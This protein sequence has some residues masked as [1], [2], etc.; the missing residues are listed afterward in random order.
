MAVWD[1]LVQ[2]VEQK[3][4]TLI[5]NDVPRTEV[6]VGNR[7]GGL[8]ALV[9]MWEPKEAL[10]TAERY[11]QVM[12]QVTEGLFRQRGH[13]PV[14]LG[15]IC[16]QKPDIYRDWCSNGH[17]WLLDA[18]ARRLLIYENQISSFLGMERE[19]EGF[20]EAKPARL[21]NQEQI[22][23][24][25]IALV[26]VNILIFFVVDVFAP[27][28]RTAY[29]TGKFAMYW[30]S[31]VEGGEYYRLV[32]SMFLHFG[33]AHLVNN[34]LILFVIGSRL[35][36]LVGK[37]KYTLVYLLSGILAGLVSMGYNMLQHREVISAGASGAVFGLVGALIWV[38]IANRG[39]ARGL[40]T[41]QILF[42]AA[43]SL[44]GGFVNRQTDN[45]AHI[46][47]LVAGFLLVM[48]LYHRGRGRKAKGRD[49]TSPA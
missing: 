48:L 18:Q 14:A 5:Q 43:L 34:M 49:M 4:F 45:A 22:P 24:V 11:N 25:T 37:V 12:S 41:R 33:S 46:G 8:Y 3:G 10:M 39:Q 1:D 31:V 38:I 32:T 47:G 27:V 26:V 42:F 40:G 6:Y 15:V 20:L 9:L 7:E 19:L 17:T 23:A 21:R 28:G 29:L 16:T 36:S 35:E 13:M 30:P 2:Y 44:Y